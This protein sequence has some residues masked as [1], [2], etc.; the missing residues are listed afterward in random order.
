V[1]FT[2]SSFVRFGSS[3]IVAVF[4]KH[5]ILPDLQEMEGKGKQMGEGAEVVTATLQFRV[6]DFSDEI[7]LM[8]LF[9]LSMKD[10]CNTSF[11]CKRLNQLAN[12]DRIWR[13]FCMEYNRDNN[14]TSLPYSPP[15]GFNWKDALKEVSMRDGPV[16]FPPEMIIPDSPKIVVLGSGNVGKSA[17]C[18]RFCYGLFIEE[19]DPTIE[20][21]ARPSIW[22][23]TDKRV[24]V[25]ILDASGIG[26]FTSLREVYM[27][28]AH[29][30]VLVYSI[31]SQC[32][33][34][35][36]MPIVNEIARVHGKVPD[37]IPIVIAGNKVDLANQRVV[38][39]I[40]GQRLARSIGASFYETRL[41]TFFSPPLRSH[42]PFDIRVINQL[43]W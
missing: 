36:L 28:Q 15:S 22:Y 5:R 40:Q 16:Q 31:V 9:K 18:T 13:A 4:G 3:F 26:E 7:L 32:T 6:T 24:Y 21:C 17:I 1:K 29:G 43:I 14:D 23:G 34:T 41:V 39:Y 2:V 30:F 11:T 27:K 37:D 33:F 19:Y 38:S 12:D 20:D 25:Y 8:V 42:P 35:D 10:L